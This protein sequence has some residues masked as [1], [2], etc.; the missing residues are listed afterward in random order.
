MLRGEVHR[1][2]QDLPEAIRVRRFVLLFKQLDP[3]DDEITRTRKGRRSVI[4]ER[5]ADLIAGLE[6]GDEAVT[7]TN[8]VTYQDG[9]NVKREVTM[10]VHDLATY[11]PPANAKARPVWSSRA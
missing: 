3:D 4:D 9:T 7:L 11:Q 2:N 6:R 5:Y 1:A 8:T 10:P